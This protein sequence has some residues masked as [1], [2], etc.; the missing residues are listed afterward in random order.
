MRDSDLWVH[1]SA[2]AR[3]CC[4]A[5]DCMPFRFELHECLFLHAA[6]ENGAM[7]CPEFDSERGERQ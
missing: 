7:P 5:R 6:S 4:A 3:G 1:A 2:F